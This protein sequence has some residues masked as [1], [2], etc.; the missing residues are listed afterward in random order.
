MMKDAD[1]TASSRQR[2]REL[3]R[4]AYRAQAR[5]AVDE[6]ISLYQSSID[7]YPTAEAYTFLGWAHSFRREYDRALHCCRQAIAIDPDFGNPYNDIGAYLIEMGRWNEAVPWLRAATRAR[8]YTA[9]HFPHYNLGRVHEKNLDWDEAEAEYAM[10]L[11]IDPRYELANQAVQRLRI[12][13]N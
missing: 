1:R 2:A 3:F 13:R 12:R 7:L 8:R 11:R 6:A 9:H 10:A 5:G 4:R